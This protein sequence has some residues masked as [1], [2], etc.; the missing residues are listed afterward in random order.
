MEVSQNAEAKR[1]SRDL[2]Q[3]PKSGCAQVMSS[4]CYA[5]FAYVDRF[6]RYCVLNVFI[7]TYIT[8]QMKSLPYQNMLMT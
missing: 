7:I 6:F 4:I 5:L 3:D 8:M 1:F 2:L